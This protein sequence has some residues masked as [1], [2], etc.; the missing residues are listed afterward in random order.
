VTLR[1]RSTWA[2]SDHSGWFGIALIAIILTGR[3]VQFGI[4]ASSEPR[5]TPTLGI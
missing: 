4:S 3:L 5:M 2:W 1:G